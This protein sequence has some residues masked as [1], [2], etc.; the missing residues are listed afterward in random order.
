MVR[1]YI[2]STF[3]ALF[4]CSRRIVLSC[5][6]SHVH[7]S[8]SILSAIICYYLPHCMMSE[9]ETVNLLASHLKYIFMDGYYLPTL[10]P[11]SSHRLYEDTAQRLTELWI[12]WRGNF[13]IMFMKL[14]EPCMSEHMCICTDLWGVFKTLSYI[15]QKSSLKCQ[16]NQ[17]QDDLKHKCI[18]K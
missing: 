17:Q 1:T 15:C 10:P 7:M 16:S 13:R 4:S 11:H 5:G 3:L 18:W 2:I 6:H 8:M 14:C 9:S 12:W